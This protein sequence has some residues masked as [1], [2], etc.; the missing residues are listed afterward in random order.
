[1]D[2]AI[3]AVQRLRVGALWPMRMVQTV[4]RGVMGA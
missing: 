1:M 3:E 2:T 4:T